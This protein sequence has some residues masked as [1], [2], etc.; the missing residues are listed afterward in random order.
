MARIYAFINPDILSWARQRAQLSVSVLAKKLGTSE[1]NLEKWER[2]D[3]APTL[4]QAQKFAAKTHVPLGYLYLDHPPEE[5]LELPDLRTLNSSQ[6]TRPSTELLEL[7]TLMRERVSWYADYLRDQGLDA[8][9]CVGRGSD[10]DTV[11]QIVND[12][13]RTLGIPEGGHKGNQDNYF[14][15]LIERIENA[16]ILV[17]KQRTVHNYR[18]LSVAEFRGFAISDPLAP[19]IFINFADVRCACLF[20]LIHELAHIWLGQ[21]GI[22]DANPETERTIEVKC[23]AIAAQFLVPVTEFLRSWQDIE[24]WRKNIE[25]LRSQFHTSRWVIARRAQSLKKITLSQYRDYTAELQAEYAS[26]N[27]EKNQRWRL[28]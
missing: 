4:R 14:N 16:G 12:I 26:R 19:L 3:R 13:R 27:N 2:G 10:Q 18:H 6:P 23:N 9:V 11:I 28:L 8:N 5:Q 25:N 20:T 7:I 24:D 17:M 21:S 22:S 1:K 15:L